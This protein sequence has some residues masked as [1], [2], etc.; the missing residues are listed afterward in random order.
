[1]ILVIAGATGS[2]KSKL[3]VSLAKKLNGEVVNADAFQVYEKLNIA[4]AKPGQ[5]E[6]GGISHH[7]FDFIPLTS[8]YDI[9]QYQKD[10]RRVIEDILSRGKTPIIAGGSGLYIRSSLYDYVFEEG[11]HMDLSAYEKLDNVALHLELERLDPE[12]AKKIHPNNRKRVLRA[13]EIC[14]LSHGKKSEL[15]HSQTHKPIYP[16]IHFFGLKPERETLY[17]IVEKRVDEMIKRGMVEENRKLL[18]EYGKEVHAFQAIG[19]KELF[20]YFEG[21]ASLESCVENIKKNTR[22]YVKRQDTFFA[23]QFKIDWVEGEKEILKQLGIE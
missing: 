2:G 11:K 10:S 4:T 3:A 21:N 6:M 18:E 16:D 9:Y 17:S 23:H 5:E 20:P 15:I 14:L 12:E 1:M 7:L 19:V 22:H 13:I 8:S